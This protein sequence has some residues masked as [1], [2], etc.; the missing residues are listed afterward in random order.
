[1][2]CSVLGATSNDP[3][4]DDKVAAANPIGM[5][6]PQIA[7]FDMINISLAISSSV[8]EVANFTATKT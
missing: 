5:I 8:A 6:G 3:I 1:M 7:I 4:A 2:A